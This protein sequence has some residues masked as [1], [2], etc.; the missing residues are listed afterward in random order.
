[1]IPFFVMIK[2]HLGR[3]YDVAYNA[4]DGV[5]YAV[6]SPGRNG[7]AGAVHRIDLSDVPSG[8]VPHI[9]SVDIT[10][11][12]YED[13]MTAGMP[14]GAYGAVFLDGDGNLF[15]GLNRGDH[16]LDGSTEASGAIYR[17]EVDWADQTAYAEFMAEARGELSLGKTLVAGR[18]VSVS[19]RWQ[20]GGEV[21]HGLILFEFNKAVKLDRV[22][23]YWD[24]PQAASSP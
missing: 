19:A 21:R 14:K 16:D 8:G 3:A 13:G 1:M 11:T 6:E 17:V 20:D 2:A 23:A 10:A 7:E 5:F 15:F 22:S 18:V 12:L 9:T 24:E 4:K